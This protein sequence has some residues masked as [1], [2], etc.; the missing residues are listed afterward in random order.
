MFKEISSAFRNVVRTIDPVVQ[1]V[2][3]SS[4]S[5]PMQGPLGLL[6]ALASH[7]RGMPA[8]S[9]QPPRS[10]LPD[11]LARQWRPGPVPARSCPTDATA[12]PAQS[13]VG[14]VSPFTQVLPPCQPVAARM[15]A[16]W[17]RPTVQLPR[18]AWS[19]LPSFR[20][21]DPPTFEG[22]HVHAAARPSSS[23]HAT[24]IQERS[25]VFGDLQPPGSPREAD[26]QLRLALEQSRTEA[27]LRSLPVID[28]NFDAAATAD[29]T[30]MTDWDDLSA[31]MQQVYPEKLTY[32]RELTA[33]QMIPSRI[34][35]ALDQAGMRSVPNDGITNDGRNNCFL[36]SLLQH[37][38][39]DYRSSH[40]ARVDQ[41]RHILSAASHFDLA[42]NE[43]ISADSEA[44]RAMVDLING[45]P[46]V[47]P[48]LRVEV[49]S[50]LNGVVHRDRLG[51]DAADARIVVIWDKGGHFEAVA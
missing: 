14:P 28:E 30:R 37:A 15:P 35:H 47:R 10:P 2:R 22:D 8:G 24:L 44:A 40:S 31:D 39:G 7:A 11:L 48:K 49:M 34:E 23:G 18:T 42:D 17:H 29:G 26:A 36:I 27:L 13:F 25:R 46:D 3:A 45:D 51:S 33:M 43:K 19:S 12:S 38:T 1:E 32:Y 50:E 9:V 21:G 6:S 5:R 41:Y 16:D 4:P 20:P